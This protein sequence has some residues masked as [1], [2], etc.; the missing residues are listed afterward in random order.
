M[1]SN[2]FCGN[3]SFQK[4]NNNNNKG[5]K[6]WQHILDRNVNTVANHSQHFL[7]VKK[8]KKM[9]ILKNLYKINK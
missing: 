9:F 4:E 7:Y 8:E 5:N 3:F 6:H 2:V 1:F